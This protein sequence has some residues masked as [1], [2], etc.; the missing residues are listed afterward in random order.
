VDP[1]T[2]PS[3]I[4]IAR[5]LRPRGN[6]G[7]VWVELHTDFPARFESLHR[8]WLVFPG[9]NRE[10]FVLENW[11]EHKGRLIL[12][13]STIDSISAAEGLAGAWV[14]IEAGQAVPLP[15]DTYWDRDLA[16]C[17]VRDRAGNTLGIVMEVMRIAGNNQ[18]VVRGD[19]GE[20]MVPMAASICIAIS[21]ERK[22][23]LVD[24]PEGLVDLNP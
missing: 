3:H 14:E 10:S 6:R 21:I 20:F 4:A 11:W 12:K 2:G 7:E 8:V 9:G 24:L 23:I 22:E 1:T 5:I 15:K 17:V 16:G 18:L 13:F 19:R